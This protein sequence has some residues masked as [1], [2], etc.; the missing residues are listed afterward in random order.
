[1]QAL[2]SDSDYLH[3]KKHKL[4]GFYPGVSLF[5]LCLQILDV[6]TMKKIL[7]LV[8]A[9]FQVVASVAQTKLTERKSSFIISAGFSIPV[10]CYASKNMSNEEAGFAKIGFHIN[11]VYE[12]NFIKNAGIA[13]KLFYSSNRVDKKINRE[14]PGISISNYKYYGLLI[15]P[16]FTHTIANNTEL[17]IRFLPGIIR[18]N[19]PTLAHEGNAVASKDGAT[20]FVWATGADLRYHFSGRN[21]FVL[22]NGD[23]TS[24]KPHFKVPALGENVKIEQHIAVVN[25]NAGVGFKF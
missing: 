3:V 9:L 20:A 6:S 19:S 13:G 10:V 8:V 21:S 4:P 23:F 22:I 16:Y 18:I 11:L 12:L 17:S 2:E 5:L 7:F 1:M 24:S 14:N 15:G 25:L